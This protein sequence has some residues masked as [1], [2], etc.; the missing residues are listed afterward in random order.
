MTLTVVNPATEEPIAQ[1]E[2]AGIDE[3]DAAVASATEA[4]PAWRAVAPGDRA[5]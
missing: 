5:R 2:Q 3:T 4:F 1:L